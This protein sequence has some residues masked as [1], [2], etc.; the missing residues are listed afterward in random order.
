M[1][2]LFMGNG[3]SL[4]HPWYFGWRYALAASMLPAFQLL[5]LF[6]TAC[7]TSFSSLVQSWAR[8]V[9][10]IMAIIATSAN[11]NSVFMGLVELINNI[12]SVV[13]T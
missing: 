6:S 2:S 8:T 12:N 1:A 13:G 11:L 3:A 9:V 7:Q 5:Q 10:A 4:D